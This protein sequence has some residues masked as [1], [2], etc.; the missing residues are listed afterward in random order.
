MAAADRAEDGQV[1]PVLG[2]FDFTEYLPRHHFGG[3]PF[4]SALVIVRMAS[5]VGG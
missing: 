3:P 5:T 1:E 4:K 2:R